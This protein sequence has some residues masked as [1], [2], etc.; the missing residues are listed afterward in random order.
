[1]SYRWLALACA[2]LLAGCA[3]SA[4]PDG[5]VCQLERVATLPLVTANGHLVVEGKLN[6][7][8]ARFILDTGAERSNVTIGAVQRFGLAKTRNGKVRMNGVGGTFV[9]P[10][11]FA[12]LELGG[13]E[14]RREVAAADLPQ[15]MAEGTQLAGLIGADLLSDYDLEISIPEHVVRLWRTHGCSGEYVP[16]TAPHVAVPL[17]KTVGNRL[18]LTVKVDGTPI[19]AVLDTG[20]NGTMLD[21]GGADR[22]GLTRAALAGDPVTGATGIDGNHVEARRHLFSTLEVGLETAH[23]VR[24]AVSGLHLSQGEML[25][26]TDWMRRQRVWISWSN[27]QMLLQPTRTPG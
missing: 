9:A 21:A 13:F 1:M 7:G 26:G 12:D 4:A 22:L 19:T 17:R 8:T 18:L 14:V 2:V 15:R 11:V 6:Q 27:R 25:L 23:A 20:A 10:T 16:W 24:L 5:G 3:G